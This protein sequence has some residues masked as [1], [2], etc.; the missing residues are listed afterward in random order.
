MSILT[1]DKIYPW[2]IRRPDLLL[3]EVAAQRPFDRLRTLLVR[4]D[5]PYEQQRIV[6]STVLWDEPAED[7]NERT[8][9]TEQALQRLGFSY[10]RATYPQWPI[11]V[12]VVIR[13][14]SAWMSWDEHEVWLGL[15]YGSNLCDVIHGNVITVTARGWVSRL[16]RLSGG[17]PRAAW[18][19]DAYAASPHA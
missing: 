11:A 1:E 4:V 19:A 7:E 15:R 14:G 9:L 18:A 3:R 10:T 13:P 6:A 5:G 17:E 16:D 8:R 12:P 2:E